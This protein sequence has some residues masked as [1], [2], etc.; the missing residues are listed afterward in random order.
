MTP[1]VA[2]TRP[3]E[4]ICTS[5]SGVVGR[6]RAMHHHQFQNGNEEHVHLGIARYICLFLGAK[7][8]YLRKF[9]NLT[10]LVIAVPG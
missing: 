10:T 1:G 4:N 3:I 5:E 9:T 7:V 6:S 2:I 8:E